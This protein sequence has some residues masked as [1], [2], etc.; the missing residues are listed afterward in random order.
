VGGVETGGRGAGESREGGEVKQVSRFA[1]VSKAIRLEKVQFMLYSQ[2]TQQ[3]SPPLS[4][5]TPPR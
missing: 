2:S 4:L 1:R 3:N 5:A